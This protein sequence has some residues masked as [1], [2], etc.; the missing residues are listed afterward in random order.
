MCLQ[1]VLPVQQESGEGFKVFNELGP[2][3]FETTALNKR[4]SLNVEAVA[5]AP[6]PI[7]ATSGE[8]YYPLIHIYKTVEDAKRNETFFCSTYKVIVRGIYVGARYQD[9]EVIVAEK[10]TPLE[11]V[12]KS[13]GSKGP[14]RRVTSWEALLLNLVFGTI[15]FYN[16]RI[17]D[18]FMGLIGLEDVKSLPGEHFDAYREY[19]WNEDCYTNHQ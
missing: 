2:E 19:L 17:S 15:S 18:Q 1:Y 4:Y 16:K 3:T 6:A 12:F 11:V 7:A 5:D 13:G 9:R 8:M 14:P 10:F